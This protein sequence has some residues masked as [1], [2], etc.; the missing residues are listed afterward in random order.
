M[1]HCLFVA[2]PSTKSQ[3]RNQRKVTFRTPIAKQ[4]A[5]KNPV[6][7]SVCNQ[8]TMKTVSILLLILI[9]ASTAEITTQSTVDWTNVPCVEDQTEYK[10]GEDMPSNDPCG[11]CICWAGGKYCTEPDCEGLKRPYFAV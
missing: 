1:K 4:I 9:S 6:T 2:K 5:V 8:K 10:S 11:S 7:C 3:K